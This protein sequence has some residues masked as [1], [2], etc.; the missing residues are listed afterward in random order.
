MRAYH[1]MSKS[2]IY[3]DLKELTEH[4]DKERLLI[5]LFNFFSIDDL[6]EFVEFIK[7]EE[8]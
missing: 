6:D 1:K 4:V 7:T 2:E 3:D 8:E 5:H